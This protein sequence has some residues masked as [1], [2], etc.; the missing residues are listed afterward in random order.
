MF[1]N[2]KRKGVPLARGL[3]YLIAGIL[4]GMVSLVAILI[5]AIKLSGCFI[6]CAGMMPSLPTATPLPTLSPTHF[7]I[8]ATPLPS[9]T[10]TFVPT[11]T[12]LPATPLA[13]ESGRLPTSEAAA[14]IG[15]IRVSHPF[16][17]PQMMV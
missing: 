12:P 3:S 17:P 9:F 15:R 4:I 16:S 13:Q 8:T 11:S 10:P 5:L 14:V 2:E 6:E 7:P 1:D